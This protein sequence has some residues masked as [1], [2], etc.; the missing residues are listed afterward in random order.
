MNKYS[1]EQGEHNKKVKKLHSLLQ[2]INMTKEPIDN[3]YIIIDSVDYLEYF[4]NEE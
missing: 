4:K 3:T 2:S 1:D